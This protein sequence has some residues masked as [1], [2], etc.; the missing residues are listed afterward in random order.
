M[1]DWMEFQNVKYANKIPAAKIEIE[2]I[3]RV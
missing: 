1:V 3:I 2:K